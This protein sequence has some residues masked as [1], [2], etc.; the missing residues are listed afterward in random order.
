MSHPY[1]L[2]VLL[3]ATTLPLSACKSPSKFRQQADTAA[4]RNVQDAQREAI[5][6]NEPFTIERPADTLRR[7]LLIDQQLPRTGNASLSS[8]DVE[9]ID[10]WPDADYL[11]PPTSELEPIIV[12]QGDQT[13]RFSLFEALQIAARNSRDYQDQKENVYIAA[14]ALDLEEDAFRNTWAGLVEGLFS[15][16]HSD[17]VRTGLRETGGLDVTRRLKSGATLSTGIALDLV[18]LLTQSHAETTGIAMDASVSI[19]LLRGSG[20]FVVTEPLTQAQRNAVYAIYTFERFKRTFVVRVASDYFN[21]L[22]QLDQLRNAEENYRQLIISTRLARRR[23]DAGRL[24]PIQV[25]QARQD[26]LRSRNRWINAQRSYESRL[27]AFK[28]QLGLP[29]D[30]RVD[31]DES[32]LQRLAQSRE[33]LFGAMEAQAVDQG[34]VPP[35]DAP[36]VLETPSREDGGP[37]ELPEERAIRLALDHRLDLRTAMGRVYDAQ[38]DVAISADD[39]RPDLTLL[40]RG[41]MGSRRSIGSAE[42]DSAQLRPERGSYSVLMSLDPALERTRE[43]NSYRFSLIDFEQ[44]VRDLQ[45]QEDTVKQQ[46]RDGLR[47]LLES[48]E[49]V[50]IQ[51]EAVRLAERRVDSTNLFLEA[52]TAQIRDVLEAQ[53]ALISA[54]NALTAAIVQYRIGE[55]A[56]QR[57]LGVLEVDE[58]GL[59]QEYDPQEAMNHDNP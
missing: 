17:G 53:E 14:L 58:Q 32:E 48:R 42:S 4:Y 45:Q 6:R 33:Q 54:R 16:D 52:G 44:Q 21:V 29:V 30:A 3:I 55:L 5:G 41:S 11:Q 59:W 50:R 15:V 49:S 23:A 51:R 57:D 39:L 47:N 13:V 27:D 40:G 37:Y 20:R 19:P 12:T 26:E 36:V 34:P 22:Q 25:D 9:P 28:L 56:M 46:V 18:Q 35:A 38:R 43:R 24:S 8:R 2:A 1:R 7:R 10:K 31:L